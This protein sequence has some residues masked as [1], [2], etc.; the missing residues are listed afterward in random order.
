MHDLYHPSTPV[1]RQTQF[2]FTRSAGR[3]LPTGT[4]DGKYQSADER[5]VYNDTS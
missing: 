1:S 5:D 3:M 4:I 2:R